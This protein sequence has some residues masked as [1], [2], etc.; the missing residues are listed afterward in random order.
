MIIRKKA[1]VI[2]RV[3]ESGEAFL[4]NTLNGQF[5]RLNKTGALIWENC[6]EKTID[7]IVE[8]LT[9]KFPNTCKSQIEGDVENFLNDLN[10]RNL[11]ELV[12]A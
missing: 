4:F 11:I 7:E 6:D 1:S 2:S 9:T 3:E 8:T 10:N 12:E 5:K